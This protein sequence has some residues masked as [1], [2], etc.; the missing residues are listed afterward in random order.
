MSNLGWDRN[1]WG[2]Q[3]ESL[4]CWLTELCIGFPFFES[5]N[6]KIYGSGESKAGRGTDF[7]KN[8][9]YSIHSMNRQAAS[10]WSGT[11]C[12]V[13]VQW[14]L[15][16]SIMQEWTMG[17]QSYFLGILI[18]WLGSMF[19]PWRMSFFF[20]EVYKCVVLCHCGQSHSLLHRGLSF[21]QLHTPLARHWMWAGPTR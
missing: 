21:L 2:V 6:A 1:R 7:S 20:C 3:S 17:K 16:F 12:Y 8:A 14:N 19:T 11:S 13:S 5:R 9:F 15:F 4:S 10:L 18:F